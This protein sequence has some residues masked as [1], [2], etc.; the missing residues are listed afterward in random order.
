MMQKV[1]WKPFISHEISTF[2]W[3]SNKGHKPLHKWTQNFWLTSCF[4]HSPP[5][6]RHRLQKSHDW[7]KISKCCD[8]IG[9]RYPNAAIWL[10]WD[11]EIHT[12]MQQWQDTYP[13]VGIWLAQATYPSTHLHRVIF[14]Y[15]K[16]KTKKSLNW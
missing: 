2:Q 1:K 10:M 13:N 4:V 3:G 14:C 6:P 8:M 12:L 9:T 16:R 15:E 11:T 7:Y 5:I